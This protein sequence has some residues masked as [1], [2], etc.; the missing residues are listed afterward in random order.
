M[1]LP[2][3]ALEHVNIPAR[4]PI[5][6]ARWYA[7]TFGLRAEDHKARGP[8]V[9]IAFEAGEPV[10]RSPELHIGLR[11]PTR[12]DLARWAGH[13]GKEVTVGAEFAAFKVFDPE[14]NCVELYS[15]ALG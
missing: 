2:A 9:L 14:G 1:S 7:D 15:P 5:G 12:A 6:L 8:G 3:L 13:F 11:G 4:D 10:N